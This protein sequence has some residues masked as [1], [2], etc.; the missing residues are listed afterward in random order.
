MTPVVIELLLILAILGLLNHR[1]SSLSR[2]MG[3]LKRLLA[4]PKPA[5]AP[6]VLKLPDLSDD[7]SLG[8]EKTLTFSRKDIPQIA[9]RMN[10]S[11]PEGE[12]TLRR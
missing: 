1:V 5:W 6:K 7:A 8:D 2:Q 10:G 12:A 9:G 11:D 3:E 4:Q